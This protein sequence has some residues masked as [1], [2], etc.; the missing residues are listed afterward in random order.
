MADIPHVIILGVGFGGVG[1]L[2]K[3]RDAN[4]RITLIDK[5]DYHTFQPLST[6]WR[7]TG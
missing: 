4:V 5:H 1:A 6:R 2:K 7:R 3:L